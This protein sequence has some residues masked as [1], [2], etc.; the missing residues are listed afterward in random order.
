MWNSSQDTISKWA[1]L[2]EAERAKSAEVS[3][4]NAFLKA[5]QTVMFDALTKMALASKLDSDD[6]VSIVA[7]I[8]RLKLMSPDEIIENVKQTGETVI[9]NASQELN[10]NPTQT[11]VNVINSAG[12][13][14]DKY[15][16]KKE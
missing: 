15:T 16:T 9:T 14:L 8:D 5:S 4:E 13:L 6:K 3:H 7:N 12:S 1:A 10:E 2:Y 11:V